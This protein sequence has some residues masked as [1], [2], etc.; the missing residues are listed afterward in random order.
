MNEPFIIGVTG[1]S[2]SGKTTFIEALGNEMDDFP[3][4]IVSQDEYYKDRKEQRTDELGITNFDLPSALEEEEFV[5]DVHRLINGEQVVREEYTFNDEQKEARNIVYRPSSILV[6]EGLFVLLN[7]VLRE[8]IDLKVFIHAKENIKV[9]RRIKRDR[10]ER[11]YPLEDVLYR[12]ENHVM[13]AYEKHIK[14]FYEQADLIINNNQSFKQALHVLCGFLHH[15][16]GSDQDE[17][18]RVLQQRENT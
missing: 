15:H 5:R 18:I 17:E 6:L 14:P 7:P 16:F 3:L 4:C 11:N 10:E 2:G 13:P 9:I 8:L 12:Y 1:G